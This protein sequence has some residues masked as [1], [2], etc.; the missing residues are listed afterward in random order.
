MV[1]TRGDQTVHLPAERILF[2]GDNIEER[3]FQ[4]CPYFP[5]ADTE[6]D[7]AHWASV[8]RGFQTFN[9]QI[10]VLGHC[11][12][13]GIRVAQELASPI[14]TVHGQVRTMSASGMAV[15]RTLAEYKPRIVPAFPDWDTRNSLT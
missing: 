1:Q 8:L 5:P 9:P 11:E 4:I 15:E 7:G 12:L 10:I 13:G 2:A 6:V 14:E 3:I